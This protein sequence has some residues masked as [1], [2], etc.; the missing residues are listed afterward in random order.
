M[1]EGEVRFLCFII[2]GLKLL[3]VRSFDLSNQ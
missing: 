2:T 1:R 3:G